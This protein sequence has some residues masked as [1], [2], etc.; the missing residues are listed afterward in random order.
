MVCPKCGS[1]VASNAFFCPSCG[2]R[3]KGSEPITRMR[4]HSISTSFYEFYLNLAVIV[5]AII[6]GVIGY[7]D[8]VVIAALSDLSK[9]EEGGGYKVIFTIIGAVLGWCIGKVLTMTPKLLLIIAQNTETLCGRTPSEPAGNAG[10]IEVEEYQQKLLT[11]KNKGL[12]S[13]QEFETLWNARR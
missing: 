4:G 10:M 7:F 5:C 8:G 3:F 11:L 1:T 13:Q 6:G 12:I 9:G 2:E